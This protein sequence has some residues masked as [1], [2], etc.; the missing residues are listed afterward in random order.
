MNIFNFINKR[1]GVKQAIPL[2]SSNILFIVAVILANSYFFFR[3]SKNELDS[4][5]AAKIKLVEINVERISNKAVWISSICSQMPVV[6][7]AYTQFYET[8][9]IEKS[10]LLIEHEMD[11][12]NSAI[13]ANTS[14]DAK[15]HF[16]LP[17]ARSFIRCWSQKRGD[18]ISPFRNTVLAVSETKK[19]IK[20]IEVGRG[21]FVIRGIVP[22][23]S[24]DDKFLGSVETLYPIS[25]MVEKSK[26]SEDEEFAIFM[27]TDL[28][29]IATRFL[30]ASSS[31]VNQDGIKKGKLIFVQSTSENFIL[32]N[33][34]AE[35]LE[36]GLSEL[37]VFEKDNF[38]YAVFPIKNYS[39]MPEGVGVFQ[40]N[41]EKRQTINA[42]M[43]LINIVLGVILVVLASLLVIIF[44]NLII[45]K[46]LK[47]SLVFLKN[48]EEGKLKNIDA[49]NRLDEIGEL[50]RHIKNMND[51]LLKMAVSIRRTSASILSLSRQLDS[52]TNKNS[53]GN[54]EITS[55][56]IID[57]LEQMNI[58]TNDNKARTS[59]TEIISRNSL[60]EVQAGSQTVEQA[61][62]GIN[63]II[64]KIS[65]MNE[66][67]EKIDVLSINASIEASRSGEQGKGF[68]V[69]AQEIRKLADKS[70]KAAREINQLSANSLEVG[71]KTKE[72]LDKIVKSVNQTAKLVNDVSSSSFEQN[73]Q[74]ETINQ[75]II[76]FFEI[77]QN[78][79]SELS[80]Y[81]QQLE[82]LVSFFSA[83]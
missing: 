6:E 66:I 38:V 8:N 30:E 55:E 14:A 40:F 7:E 39:G 13:K 43:K 31:N 78:N 32:N 58:I 23:F 61:I 48:V 21:G 73:N 60:Q 50:Q 41:I 52:F 29:E 11:Y 53:Y 75:S 81:S 34:E 65:V 47:K 62:E 64:G 22:I 10:S 35:N 25:E 49:S 36:K 18:D 37:I 67:A 59:E 26:L 20:G 5:V 15:I 82:E 46:D 9:D 69:V 68:G 4:K 2:I 45:N 19:V 44:T 74:I 63:K 83:E 80:N 17:P 16:H 12:I 1:I 24:R 33:L 77:T 72:T 76:R 54:A 27:H 70:K 28:L 57:S 56:E 79:A 42:T 71:E 3:T 51:R